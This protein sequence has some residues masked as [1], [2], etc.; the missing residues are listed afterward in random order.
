MARE[1][2]LFLANGQVEAARAIGADS[3]ERWDSDAAHGTDPLA[4]CCC[5][6]R[7][8]MCMLSCGHICCVTCIDK[9]IRLMKKR[10][11]FLCNVEWKFCRAV[12]M[13]SV[14]PD[15]VCI[16]CDKPRVHIMICGHG[17]C[18]CSTRVCPVC[19]TGPT[20][21]VFV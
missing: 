4:C 15:V 20:V 14:K 18:R 10:L 8:P 16:E 6:E 2:L 13:G 9:S 19:K 17:T 3:G 21:R 12:D 11:C 1:Q 7:K 5:Y